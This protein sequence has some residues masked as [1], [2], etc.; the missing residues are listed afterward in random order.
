MDHSEILQAA[1]PSD[2][3]FFEQLGGRER[4]LLCATADLLWKKFKES[5]KVEELDI[6]IEFQLKV[7]EQ[8]PE[9]HPDRAEWL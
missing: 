9:N 8:T 5:H 2:A 4:K 3:S 7:L 6:S 1:V